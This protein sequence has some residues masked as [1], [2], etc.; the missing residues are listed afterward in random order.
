MDE[1][2]RSKAPEGLQKEKNLSHARKISLKLQI[3][4]YTAT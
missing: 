3:L 2:T 1:F 4:V